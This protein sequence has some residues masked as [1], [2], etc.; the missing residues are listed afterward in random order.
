MLVIRLKRTGRSGH[1]QYRVVVQDRR[2]HPTR[3]KVVAYLGSYDPHTKTVSLDK[4][5]AERYLTSG[6]QPSDRVAKILKSEGIKLPTWVKLAP[7]KK[8]TVRNPEKR[9]STRP[10][11][12]PAP[13]PAEPV[14]EG[15]EAPAEEPPAPEAPTEEAPAE[16]PASAEEAPVAEPAEAAEPEAPAVEESPAAVG[17]TPAA[18]AESVSEPVEAET[19]AEAPVEAETPEKPVAPAE[20]ETPVDQPAA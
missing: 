6:A 10:A 8:R 9:R 2:F 17:K 19:P 5:T 13:A 18:D 3:G 4:A 20:P 12:E 16:A 7:P 1:A 14:A 11:G 15:E